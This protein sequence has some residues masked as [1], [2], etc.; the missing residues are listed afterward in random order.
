MAE[1]VTLVV[2]TGVLAAALLVTNG[3][4]LSDIVGGVC[5]GPV[6]GGV[7]ARRFFARGTP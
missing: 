1:R 2:A 3:H 4:W 7:V 6:I 5:L